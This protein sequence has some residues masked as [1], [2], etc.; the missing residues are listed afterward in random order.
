MYK[1]IG[2]TIK[3]RKTGRVA[4]VCKNGLEWIDTK[5]FQVD[6]DWVEGVSS[7]PKINIINF[8]YCNDKEI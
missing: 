1:N 5:E 7:V 4:V 8:S 6:W 2:A 3:H